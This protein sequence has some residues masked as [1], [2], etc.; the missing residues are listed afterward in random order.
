MDRSIF[1]EIYDICG[2]EDY[3]GAYERVVG[4]FDRK[5]WFI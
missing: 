2:C 5:I 1:F 4:Y 3:A